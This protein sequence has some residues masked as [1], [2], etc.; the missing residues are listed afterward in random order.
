[1]TIFVLFYQ[2]EWLKCA[3]QAWCAVHNESMVLGDCEQLPVVT[4]LC[5]YNDSLEVKLSNC[6]V[7]FQV[8]NDCIPSLINGNE[9]NTIGRDGQMTDL[10]GSL[11]G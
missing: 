5:C 10:M 11:K 4:E 1:M 9:H 2:D 3:V 8:E 7:S 6:E